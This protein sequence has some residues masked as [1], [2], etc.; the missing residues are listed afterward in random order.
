MIKAH[1]QRVITMLAKRLSLVLTP[2][3]AGR[4]CAALSPYGARGMDSPVPGGGGTDA[5]L[6]EIEDWLGLPW[7]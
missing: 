3:G 6:A 7:E 5:T 2:P 1:Q 4:N